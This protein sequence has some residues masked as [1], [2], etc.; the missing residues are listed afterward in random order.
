VTRADTSRWN[1]YDVL[2]RTTDSTVLNQATLLPLP[3]R[4]G[5]RIPALRTKKHPQSQLSPAGA[6]RRLSTWAA[7]GTWPP[8]ESRKPSRDMGTS[9]P[10][11]RKT[12]RGKLIRPDRQASGGTTHEHSRALLNL[13]L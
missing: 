11:L 9:A 12:V 10:P 13:A 2:S 4:P 8:Q 1:A 7:V 5:A 3:K 6:L